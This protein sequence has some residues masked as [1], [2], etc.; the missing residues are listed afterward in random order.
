MT[1]SPFEIEVYAPIPQITTA[2]LTGYLR[3][4]LDVP[5][6]AEPIDIFRIREGHDIAN[7]FPRSLLTATDGS[8]ST[9]SIAILS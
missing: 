4:I 7:I 5:V 1:L 9:G 6:S 3:G 8:F 2:S